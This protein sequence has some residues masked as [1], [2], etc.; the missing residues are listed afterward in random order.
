[1]TNDER[2]E[3]EAHKKR[4]EKQ[5]NDMYYGKSMQNKGIQNLS[6]PPFLKGNENTPKSKGQEPIKDQV[7][8]T[9]Q[10]KEKKEA[11]TGRM[12]LLELLNF[13]NI[14]M[15]NDRITILALCLLLSSEGADELLIL[16]LIY[17]ML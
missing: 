10:A 12:N 17:I 13:K 2:R 14:T 16:A 7:Q 11:Q 1:M 15:D 8:K 6:M 9:Q 5:M 3:F 4:A